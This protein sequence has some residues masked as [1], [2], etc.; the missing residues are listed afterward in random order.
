VYTTIPGRPSHRPY[1]GRGGRE[2][3]YVGGPTFRF[4]MKKEERKRIGKSFA[5]NGYGGFAYTSATRS[6]SA[7]FFFSFGIEMDKKK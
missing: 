5:N 6:L 2:C 1:F 4:Y 7:S 3:P